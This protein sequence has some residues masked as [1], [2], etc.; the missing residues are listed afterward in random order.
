MET[1]TGLPPSRTRQTSRQI[2]SEATAEPPG[3]STCSTTAPT[4]SSSRAARNAAPIESAPIWRPVAP[5]RVRPDTIAPR[6]STSARWRLRRARTCGRRRGR[7]RSA[8]SSSASAPT[9]VLHGG[10]RLVAVSE[11]ID[12][13]DVPRLGSCPRAGIGELADS[14]GVQAPP[15]GDRPD[16]V[17]E[18]RL[19][20]PIERGP[21]G[22]GEFGAQHDG[23]RRS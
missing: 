14:G 23:Q 3:E 13:P 12:Q 17:G 20:E 10:V 5:R 9:R 6:A 21:V 15:V 18:D 7:Q 4:W 2:V 19:G 1:T 8:N 11:P 22:L 16:R